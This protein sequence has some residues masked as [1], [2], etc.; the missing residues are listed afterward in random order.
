MME[1]IRVKRDDLI[2]EFSELRRMGV[3]LGMCKFVKNLGIE[4]VYGDIQ[5]MESFKIGFLGQF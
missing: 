3:L 5:P 2:E 1:D 4:W